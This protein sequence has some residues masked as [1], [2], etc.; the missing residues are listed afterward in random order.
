M[1]DD[2]AQPGYPPDPPESPMAPEESL[3]AK[4]NRRLQKILIGLSLLWTAS[5]S[6][7]AGDAT[8]FLRLGQQPTVV[9]STSA[10]VSPAKAVFTA[11]PTKH[12]NVSHDSDGASDPGCTDQIRA[13]MGQ[14]RNPRIELIAQKDSPFAMVVTEYYVAHASDGGMQYICTII[15]PSSVSVARVGWKPS[16]SSPPR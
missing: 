12:S 7:V 3:L 1:A 2:L 5:A 8:D 4:S 15:L 9:Y 16:G 14:D 6:A 13:D 11:M 10:P